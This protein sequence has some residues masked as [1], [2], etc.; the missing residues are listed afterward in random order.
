M[1]ENYKSLCVLY[2]GADKPYPPHEE[3]LFYKFFLEK[4]K[5]NILEPMCGSGRFL[6]PFL[7]DG[8]EIEAFDGS[9]P[10]LTALS[11]RLNENKISLNYKYSLF[12]DYVFTK[13]YNLI[14]IPS[15]SLSLIYNLRDFEEAIRRIHDNLVDQGSF[16]FEVETP[17]I[18]E[19]DKSD[20]KLIASNFIRL[21]ER[22][23]IIGSFINHSYIDN[24][25]T[26]SCR[27]DMIS[28]DYIIKTEFEDI[29][30]RLFHYEEI[31]M[32][33][34]KVGFDVI[35]YKNFQKEIYDPSGLLP[36]LLI[37]ECLKK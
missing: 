9:Q 10:M 20:F 33:L 16:V 30:V 26:I 7:C 8:Y 18:L 12:Q 35:C 5:N 2:Y 11:N 37:L 31:I 15:A 25:L 13:K 3:Y 14:Y 29:I 17:E 4:Y 36:K 28:N 22:D 1:I 24:V 6:I 32:I 21:N 23:K 34:N 19:K 27:Y